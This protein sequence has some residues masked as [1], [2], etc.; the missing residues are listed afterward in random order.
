[1][2]EQQ[3]NDHTS[4]L[5]NEGRRGDVRPL[6]P[7]SALTS[8]GT[9]RSNRLLGSNTDAHFEAAVR[10]S[11]DDLTVGSKGR[12]ISMTISLFRGFSFKIEVSWNAL[13]L[14][15]QVITKSQ[16]EA[17]MGESHIG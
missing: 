17:V 13:G 11:R 12:P 14:C 3:P 7:S 4:R 16:Q 1:M 15:V 2:T 6:R 9:R 5:S 10:N 8:A